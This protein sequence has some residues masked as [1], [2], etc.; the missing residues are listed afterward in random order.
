MPENL[1]GLET[2]NTLPF[3]ELAIPLPEGPKILRA[4]INSRVVQNLRLLESLD[5]INIDGDIQESVDTM[6]Q[7]ESVCGMSFTHEGLESLYNV[8]GDHTPQEIVDFLLTA[9]IPLYLKEDGRSR[10]AGALTMGYLHDIFCLIKPEVATFDDKV[11]M[12]ISTIRESDMSMYVFGK[13]IDDC[14]GMLTLDGTT[15]EILVDR[16]FCQMFTLSLLSQTTKEEQ[17]YF[18]RGSKVNIREITLATIGASAS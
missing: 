3:S 13:G 4:R 14:L 6:L 16:H 8:F 15:S 12:V 11:A 9:Q 17:D 1:P 10:T 18:M 7:G 5:L 2:L